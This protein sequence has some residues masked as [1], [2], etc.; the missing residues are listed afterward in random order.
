VVLA[1]FLLVCWEQLLI[2]A[3]IAAS[4]F[5]ARS[6]VFTEPQFSGPAPSPLLHII[7]HL[8]FGIGIQTLF[9]A[10]M[11]S[12]LFW[13]IRKLGPPTQQPGVGHKTKGLP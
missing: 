10:G 6:N 12:L 2:V 5:T 8:T 9:G 7:G 1:V 13:L 3:A 4:I 11:A